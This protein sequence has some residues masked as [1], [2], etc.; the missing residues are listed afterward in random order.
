MKELKSGIR[1]MWNFSKLKATKD[2]F[3]LKRHL[4]FSF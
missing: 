3:D 1:E 2:T 4:V